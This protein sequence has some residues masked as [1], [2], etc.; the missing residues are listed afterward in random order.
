MNTKTVSV[1]TGGNSGIGAACVSVLAARGDIVIVLDVQGPQHGTAPNN[2]ATQ[3]YHCDVS[4]E[5]QVRKTAVSIKQQFGVIN[6][7]INSAGV[8]QSP[9][10]PEELPMSLWDK[11]TQIDQRGTYLSCAVFGSIMAEQGHGNIV[12]IASITGSRSVPLHAYAPAKAAVISMTQCLAVEWGRSGVRVN[13]VSPGYTL[14]PALQAAINNGQRDVNK[15]CQQSALGRMVQ[16]NEVANTIAFLT[17]DQASAVTGID[18]PVDAGWL[19]G[20]SW[21][22]YDGIPAARNT[23]PQGTS[24]A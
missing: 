6:N 20:T 19:A 22:T 24:N 4:D 21:Q 5:D 16:P 10:S 18:L 9:V 12:N 14:T 1:V 23:Q 7:L 8:I 2:G 17:S 3:F 13:S 11:V 15:L